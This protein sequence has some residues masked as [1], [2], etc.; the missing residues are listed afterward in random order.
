MLSFLLTNEPSMALCGKQQYWEKPI[1]PRV[2]K[3]DHTHTPLV[4]RHLTHSAPR[5]ITSVA[6]AGNSPFVFPNSK[7]CRHPSSEDYF[8]LEEWWIQ[9]LDFS[10]FE[11]FA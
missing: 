4:G 8:S 11:R 7:E 1:P 6:V 5:S 2:D 3:N 10:T 9:D